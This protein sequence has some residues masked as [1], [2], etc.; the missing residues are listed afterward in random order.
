MLFRSVTGTLSLAAGLLSLIVFFWS[1]SF[2]ILYAIAD[3]EFDKE[4]GLRSIPQ[5]VGRWWSLFISA[6]GHTIVLPLLVILYYT[7]DF[8]YLYIAGASIFSLLLIY[9]HIIV[10]PSDIS[11]LNAAFF[12]SN[13]F[14]SAIF[15]IFAIADLLI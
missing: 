2:D 8:G 5:S 6:A 10:K 4:Q 15:A 12:T 11:R 7:G 1:G 13:G 14:A 9:Q 3:E